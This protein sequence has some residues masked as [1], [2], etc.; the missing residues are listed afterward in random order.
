MLLTGAERVMIK[1]LLTQWPEALTEQEIDF[2]H[3]L[4]L[5]GMKTAKQAQVLGELVARVQASRAVV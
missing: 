5:R 4:Q 1:A 2:L 3:S